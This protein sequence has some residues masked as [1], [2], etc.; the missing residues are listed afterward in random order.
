MGP[1]G[2]KAGHELLRSSPQCTK[3]VGVGL[4]ALLFAVGDWLCALGGRVGAFE[5]LVGDCECSLPA[6]NGSAH[7]SSV[8][9]SSWKGS[10]AL[11]LGLVLG[12]VFR[13]W[14]RRCVK[15]LSVRRRSRLK[16]LRVT[17]V[18][19]VPRRSWSVVRRLL[20]VR[21]VLA[22][23]LKAEPTGEEAKGPRMK[24]W[25]ALKKWALCGLGSL[26]G[27]EQKKAVARSE[28]LRML[29]GLP[30]PVVVNSE[31]EEE[32]IPDPLEAELAKPSGSEPPRPSDVRKKPRVE[33]VPSGEPGALSSPE[34]VSDALDPEVPVYLT[35]ERLKAHRNKGHQPYL[36]CCDTCQSARGRVPARRKHMKH[37]HGPGEL[38]VDFGFFGKNVRFLLMVHVV[39]GYIHTVVL[40]PED[41]VPAVSVCKAF[42][43][44]GLSGLDIVVH[45]D[46]E[47]LLES[48][49]R[50]AAKHRTFGGR[51]MHW[52]P[53]AINR[54]QAKGIVERH[55]CLVKEAG[56]F[57]W[58]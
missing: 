57:G 53:F 22:C 17:L 12:L 16:F 54:P 14:L 21:G 8:P 42:T 9:R 13:G 41:E 27:S 24:R 43:E 19:R 47:N 26:R 55:V 52:V 3:L 50:N 20:F 29:A 36:S 6:A 40:G 51:S 23:K 30:T 44:M 1:E 48:V 49:F 11:A 18:G 46:Q 5:C 58:A 2:L 31:S 56:L 39:S 32:L 7:C 4:K 35:S 38:Q 15:L 10:S 37:H 25:R 33:N 28:A 34:V 45:G